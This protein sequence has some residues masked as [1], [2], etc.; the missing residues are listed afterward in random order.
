LVLLLSNDRSNSFSRSMLAPGRIA[1]CRAVL[2]QTRFD[3]SALGYDDR[4]I[5]EL[6][7]PAFI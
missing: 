2:Q 4:T 3:W 5:D 7:G 1:R 6:V